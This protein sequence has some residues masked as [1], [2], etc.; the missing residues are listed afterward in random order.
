MV[1]HITGKWIYSPDDGDDDDDDSDDDD[2]DNN[3][4]DNDH[5]GH[6]YSPINLRVRYRTVKAAKIIKVTS[7]NEAK[8]C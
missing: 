5:R 2:N 1:P 4:D 6:L 8:S 7:N 3:N